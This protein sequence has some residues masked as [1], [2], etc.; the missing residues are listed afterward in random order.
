[1]DRVISVRTRQ[2]LRSPTK[3]K[4]A[5]TQDCANN[6]QIIWLSQSPHCRR[7]MTRPSPNLPEQRSRINDTC[8]TVW[9]WTFDAIVN[10]LALYAASYYAICIC[11][12]DYAML[13]NPVNRS[14]RSRTSA[15]R[16]SVNPH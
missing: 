7:V 3:G 2:R 6:T 16:V 13:I 1:M 15:E 4:A 11:P 8:G 14:P 10:G 5:D 12:V 9:R